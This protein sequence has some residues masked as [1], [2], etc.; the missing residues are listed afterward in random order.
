VVIH[1]KGI[2]FIL[3]Q[4]IDP[5]ETDLRLREVQMNFE[6]LDDILD[7]AIEKEHMA[8]RFYEDAASEE[9]MSGVIEMLKELADEERKHV[10]ML[11]ELK[12]KGAVHG[13]DRYKYK[14]IPDMK[15]SD[16]IADVTYQKGMS[17]HQILMV[18]IK[19]EEKALKLY[20][21]LLAKAEDEDAQ[22][23]FKIFCQE[24][25]RHKLMFETMY[26]DYMAEMGD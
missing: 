18:A 13:T 19:N 5:V 22:K 16:Y 8:V 20:N 4:C 3:D 9:S 14:W 25:A 10:R 21:E 17:Y 24:E 2:H 7:F 6:S 1:E 12:K 26:D 11:T 15:R 23:L